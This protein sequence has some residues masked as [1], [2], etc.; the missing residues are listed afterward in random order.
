MLL[1]FGLGGRVGREELDAGEHLRAEQRRGV[2]HADLCLECVLLEVG[3]V[4][5]ADDLAGEC[6]VGQDL[7]DVSADEAL[8]SRAVG[9]PLR[10]QLTRE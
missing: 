8:L 4:G 10:V 7:D 9:R 5:D 3:L 6:L 2:E 1:G